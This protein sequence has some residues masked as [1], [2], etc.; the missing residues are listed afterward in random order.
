MQLTE[1]AWQIVQRANEE[2]RA[3]GD[4]YIGSDHILL[5]MLREGHGAGANVLDDLGVSYDRVF[6]RLVA[7]VS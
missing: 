6:E 4:D 1:R 2:A 5:A 3:L 7:D